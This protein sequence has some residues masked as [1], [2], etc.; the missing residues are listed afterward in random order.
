MKTRI[1]N[2]TVGDIINFSC[3]V[4]SVVLGIIAFFLPP[5]GHIDNSVLLFIAEVGVFSTI[6]RV[7]DFIK[8]V[9]DSHTNLK[10]NKGDTSIIIEGDNEEK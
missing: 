7:P 6:S 1:K 5:K 4:V 8:S 2:A 10:I 9:R 3:F